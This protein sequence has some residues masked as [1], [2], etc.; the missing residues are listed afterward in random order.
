MVGVDPALG[1]PVPQVRAVIVEA[2]SDAE[3]HEHIRRGVEASHRLGLA[4]KKVRVSVAVWA[5]THWCGRCGRIDVVETG[6]DKGHGSSR[7]GCGS[8]AQRP[9]PGRPPSISIPIAAT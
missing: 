4:D 9:W 6:T 5:G 8:A 1:V 7:A 2:Q 3:L